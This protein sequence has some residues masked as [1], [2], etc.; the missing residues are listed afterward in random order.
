VVEEVTRRLVVVA[1]PYMVRP[2][3]SVPI[4]M[5]E[6]ALMICPAV[7]TLAL[8]RL[9]PMVCAAVPVYE[10]EKVSVPFVAE[11]APSVPPRRTPE[12]LLFASCALPMVVVA[13]MEP[14]DA[15]PRK[16]TGLPESPVM[17]NCEEV[18]LV[19]VELRAVKFWSVVEPR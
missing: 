3:P 8:P 5:V 15:R 2:P 17:A 18:A 7:Q 1:P 11:S 6:E 9:R 14:P 19:E 16:V 4:P 10:P 13:Y 12:I